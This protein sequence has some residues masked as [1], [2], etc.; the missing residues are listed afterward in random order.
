MA[1]ER[2]AT[3][4]DVAAL[5]GVSI[6]TVSRYLADAASVQPFTAYRIRDAVQRLGYEPNTFARSLRRGTSKTVGVV[7]P[8]LEFYFGKACR[9]I[10]D[11]F[12]SRGYATFLCESDNDAQKEQFFVR[13]LI[14][15]RVAGLVVASSGLNAAFL[16][17]TAQQYPHMVMLDR[18]E[19]AGC[20]IVAEDH[21]GNAF[22]LAA[23]A[24]RRFACGR[25][26]LLLGEQN[27][28]NTRLCMAGVR[29]AFE[30]AGQPFGTVEAHY[31][32]RREGRM[33][34]AVE[35]ICGGQA[36]GRPVVLAF[37]PDF[38]EQT[39]IAL[40]RRGPALL[41]Q[42]DLA[43]LA[44]EN[45]LDK[46][47]RHFACIVQQPEYAGI[48]AAQAL[49]RRLEEPD[50]TREPPRMYRVRSLPRLES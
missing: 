4:K 27:A 38:L 16:Q 29:R 35:Q 2:K 22:Q 42:I 18:A 3:I 15:Q 8:N 1:G 34:R 28:V 6:S 49:H 5:A 43:G 23:F 45:S 40:N 17:Q 48:T 33:E 47:G 32:C 25:M 9:A 36:A 13:E 44:M 11:Y 10:S 12:Y 37:E 24:L 50:G 21:E 46:L 30:A 20:D 31:G 14:G 41:D 39:V 7:V 19:E 26:H